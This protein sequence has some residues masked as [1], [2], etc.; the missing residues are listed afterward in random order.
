MTERGIRVGPFDLLRRL[1]V[2]PEPCPGCATVVPGRCPD[3]LAPGPAWLVRPR[4]AGAPGCV[5]AARYLGAMRQ[6]VLAYK[7]HGRLDLTVPLA[8]VLA[9]LVARFGPGPTL[10]IPIP[11]TAA[12]RRRRGFDPVV[13]LCRR[14]PVGTATVLTMAPRPDSVGLSARQ[15]RRIADATIGVRA[16]R[17]ASVRR[18]AARVLLVDDVVTSGATT[19]AAARALRD[20][21]ITVAATVALAATPLDSRQA[22]PSA[23]AGNRWGGADGRSTGNTRPFG[24]DIRPPTR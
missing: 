8:G 1:L 15:R 23:R 6:I 9:G 2:A 22:V 19:A 21:G 18:S 13:R 10:L 16:G 11:A 12:A 5:A 14:L 7:E 17:A 4:A 24:G 3:C 20:V